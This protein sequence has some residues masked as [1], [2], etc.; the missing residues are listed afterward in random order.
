MSALGEDL[1]FDVL[2]R[3]PAVNL[4]RFRCVSKSWLA[5]ID[6]SYFINLHLNRSVS[7]VKSRKIIAIGR[8]G[9]RNNDSCR[10]FIFY[11]INFDFGF[12]IAHLQEIKPPVQYRA[13]WVSFIGSYRFLICIRYSNEKIVLWNPSIRSHRILPFTSVEIEA[14][15]CR[16]YRRYVFSYGFGYDS[17]ID[18]HKV[19]RMVFDRENG[20]YEVKVYSLKLDTWKNIEKFPLRICRVSM[21]SFTNGSVNWLVLENKTN[22]TFSLLVLCLRTEVCQSVPLPE[23]SHLIRLWVDHCFARGHGLQK[24]MDNKKS[25]FWT[26]VRLRHTDSDEGM[27]PGEIYQHLKWINAKES[28]QKNLHS[29]FQSLKKKLHSESIEICAGDTS[30]WVDSLVRIERSN[31]KSIIRKRASHLVERKARGE[32]FK[33][34]R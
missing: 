31:N 26:N 34:Q 29:K 10:D 14:S 11:A 5:L 7:D 9:N 6:S 17:V 16:K 22:P 25:D 18:D 19:V 13:D 21:P 2:S 33:K 27:V 32:E 12:K 23:G 20:D 4:L 3:L 1:L 30:Y 28:L 15:Q 8:D 24:L